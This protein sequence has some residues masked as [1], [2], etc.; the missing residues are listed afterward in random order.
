MS[1]WQ[2]IETAP[3]DGTLILLGRAANEEHDR[4]AISVPGRWYDGFEDA[5]DDM[6]HDDGF[7]DVDFNGDFSCGR[8]FGN[9]EYQSRGY[10]PTHWQ[11]LPEPPEA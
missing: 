1:A 10:Q 8:S 5:P 6:G 3:R 4:D 7:M 11:P 9:P 2:P